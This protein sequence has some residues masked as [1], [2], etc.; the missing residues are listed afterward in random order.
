MAQ[1]TFVPT[2][3]G[4]RNAVYNGFM[5][6]KKRENG[7]HIFW[8]CTRRDA[9]GCKGTLQTLITMDG[10]RVSEIFRYCN[11]N[12]LDNFERWDNGIC[13]LY[14]RVQ[15]NQPKAPINVINWWWADQCFCLNTI[16]QIDNFLKKSI[17]VDYRDLSIQSSLGDNV[18]W[19]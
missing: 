12:I 1:L 16:W 4:G 8:S 2:K 19:N 15:K 11:C 17:S 10:P 3:R 13:K 7:T 14:L 5:Y 6:N 18:F 9:A